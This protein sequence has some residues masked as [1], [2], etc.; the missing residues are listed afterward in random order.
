VELGLA[1][2]AP[3]DATETAETTTTAV[4]PDAIPF[5]DSLC[6]ACAKLRH[7]RTATSTYMLCTA[8]ATKYPRQPVV[9]CPAFSARSDGR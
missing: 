3:P 1:A 6:H 8:L 5:A 7:V 9:A 2:E 4:A